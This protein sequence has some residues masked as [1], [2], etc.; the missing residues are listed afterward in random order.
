MCIRDSYTTQGKLTPKYEKGRTGLAPVYEQAQL[1][2]LRREMNPAQSLIRRDISDKPAK[3]DKPANVQT[4]ALVR[5]IAAMLKPAVSLADKWRLTIDEAVQLSGLSKGEI[6]KAIK[7]GR[8][9]AE[10]RGAHGSR[11]IKREDLL[12]YNK[13]Y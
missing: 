6:K 7:A 13:K 8:L 5:Q 4:V 10:K 11:V 12:A 3:R 2:E 1:D 9:K